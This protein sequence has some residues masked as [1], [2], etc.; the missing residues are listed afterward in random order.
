MFE[1]FT[2]RA[3]RAIV[4]GQ[5]EALA[6]G[7]DFMGT[8]HLLL[9]LVAVPES[10]AGALL[11]AAGA[12]PAAARARAVGILEADGIFGTGAQD[13]KD[14][15]SALGIDVDEIKRR[16]D[17]TFGEGA[18]Q[19]PRPAYTPHAKKALELTVRAWR[20]CGHD[21]E[22]PGAGIGTE[23]MLLGL[24]AEPE[25]RSHR[26]LDA[27]AVDEEALRAAA[28]ERAGADGDPTPQN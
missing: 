7:H 13:A 22:D 6:L 24:L 10:T 5:D 17:G 23:H 1:Y 9:G 28:R 19:Y 4:A 2:E 18:F 20:S 25:G 8:E 26:V 15:L 12:E 27:L 14:A 3:K 16:A 11:A 21:P